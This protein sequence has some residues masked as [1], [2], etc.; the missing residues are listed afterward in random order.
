MRLL[1]GAGA[2]GGQSTGEALSPALSSEA[3]GTQHHWRD[4]QPSQRDTVQLEQHGPSGRAQSSWRDALCGLQS[5]HPEE[6]NG[7][8]RAWSH[9]CYLGQR[10]LSW[11]SRPHLL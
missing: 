3:T 8:S 6:R 10:T 7:Q 1:C 4:T 9:A 2:P 5:G 11:L